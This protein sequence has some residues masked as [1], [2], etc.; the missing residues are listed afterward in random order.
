V[1]DPIAGNGGA[2]A[3]SLVILNSRFATSLSPASERLADLLYH[4]ATMFV[5]P[6][7]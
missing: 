6:H 7:P 2:A 5:G 3:V 4:S 1:H